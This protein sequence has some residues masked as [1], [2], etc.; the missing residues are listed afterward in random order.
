MACVESDVYED[1]DFVLPP[2]IFVAEDVYEERRQQ[3]Q[4][5]GKTEYW[6]NGEDRGRDA[7]PPQPGL[8]KLQE[9]IDRELGLN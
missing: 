3:Q 8:L 4:F 5:Q 2:L 1:E 9:M 7:P 6:L